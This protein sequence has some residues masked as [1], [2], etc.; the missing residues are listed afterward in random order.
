[1]L[2]VYVS[3]PVACFRKGLAREYLETEPVP[4]PSTCYGFLL[5]LVGEEKRERHIGARIT[6]TLL[7]HPV[8]STVFR[9]VWK[10]D[11]P[12]LGASG[13]IRPDYQ[14]LLTGI[15]LILWLDS[16][17]E[18]NGAPTLENRV[19]TALDPSKRGANSRFGGL[20]LG[21]STHLVNDVSLVDDRLKD[22]LFKRFFG[23]SCVPSTYLRAEQGLLG[24]PV[25]V[26]HVG[27]AETAFVVGQMTGIDNLDPPDPA[28]MPRIEPKHGE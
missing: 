8:T 7:N 10:V 17:E 13:N 20:S 5:S 3:V 15:E 27:S 11:K 6:A 18:Q 12:L 24:L 25:W 9:T 19:T 22:I 2:G 26:D 4:P 1:M 16:S 28:M 23:N 14:Q 21:E